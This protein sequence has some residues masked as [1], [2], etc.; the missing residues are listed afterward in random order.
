MSGD[1]S[2]AAVSL[3]NI[4]RFIDADGEP[5]TNPRPFL[6]DFAGCRC[7]LGGKHG[8]VHCADVDCQG[9][10]ISIENE[11]CRH[12][13]IHFGRLEQFDGPYR[14]SHRP[15]TLDG[16]RRRKHGERRHDGSIGSHGETGG[17]AAI[18]DPDRDLVSVFLDHR[19]SARLNASD[20]HSI[21]FRAGGANRTIA[22]GDAA[23]HPIPGGDL[24]EDG[25]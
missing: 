21:S 5:I 24:S 6:S 18:V 16:A 9:C 4:E 12:V 17:I 2:L 19:L 22:A 15:V 20:R 7:Q 1:F 25:Q 11:T 8:Q 23:D 10:A 13:F 3:S 14:E